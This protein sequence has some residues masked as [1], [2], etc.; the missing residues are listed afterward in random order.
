M[1]AADIHIQAMSWL[2]LIDLYPDM[3]KERIAVI[4]DYRRSNSSV[5]SVRFIILEENTTLGPIIYFL[6]SYG[7]F[8]SFWDVRHEFSDL[9]FLTRKLKHPPLIGAVYQITN[10]TEIFQCSIQQIDSL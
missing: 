10:F 7:M 4:S 3:F 6:T 5:D 9:R 8:N 1:A 2:R